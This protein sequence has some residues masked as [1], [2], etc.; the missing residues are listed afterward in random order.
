[1]GNLSVRDCCAHWTSLTALRDLHLSNL[2]PR[3]E[4][5]SCRVEG[6]ST[7][8]ASTATLASLL[9]RLTQLTALALDRRAFRPSVE[10]QEVLAGAVPKLPCLVQLRLSDAA[11]DVATLAHL[12]Q[13][14]AHLLP[15]L[16]VTVRGDISVR[17]HIRSINESHLSGPDLASL[18]AM[19]GR[20]PFD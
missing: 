4:G 7:Q 8:D 14:A 11:L 9:A 20:R 1:M 16:R 6:G 18:N 12:A 17:G 5:G 10:A 13:Q 19:A 15:Q 3:L 2:L